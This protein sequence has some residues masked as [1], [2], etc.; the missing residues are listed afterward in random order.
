MMV[1]LRSPQV[2]RPCSPQVGILRYNAGNTGSV[3]RAL[4]RLNIPS[5][6]VEKPAELERVSGIIFPG[7]GA[8]GA[9]M[10]RLRETGWCC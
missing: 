10:K 9:A 2:V 5:K 8:A 4:A 1:R 3:Q 7:A 6:I